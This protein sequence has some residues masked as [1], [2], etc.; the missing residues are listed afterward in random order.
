M[1]GIFEDDIKDFIFE[2]LI[3]EGLCPDSGDVETITDI[4]I[5]LL[6]EYEFIDSIVYLEEDDE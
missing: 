1:N 4:V 5:D 6:I 2:K 3:K